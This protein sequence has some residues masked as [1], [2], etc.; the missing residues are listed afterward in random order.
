MKCE[1]C[2]AEAST[3]CNVSG[4]PHCGIHLCAEHVANVFG[5]HLH[6][7]DGNHRFECQ[8]QCRP[9]AELERVTREAAIVRGQNRWREIRKGRGLSLIEV[10]KRLGV[11][12]PRVSNL[13]RLLAVCT[14]QESKLFNERIAK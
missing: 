2:E 5:T 11:S 9:C 8:A 3:Q 12:V 14:P 1:F 13:E 6:A 10:A 7:S 4:R